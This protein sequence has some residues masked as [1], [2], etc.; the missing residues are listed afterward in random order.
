MVVPTLNEERHVESLL[1][2]L[3]EQSQT[4][5]EV[6]IVDGGSKDKT[7]DIA[8]LYDARV[9]VLP[10]C[11]EFASR[12]VGAKMARGEFLLFTC[13]DI[14]FPNGLLAKVIENFDQTP[15]L[16]ALTGPGYPFGASFFGRI[17]YIVYNVIR[18][19]FAKFPRPFKRFS[20]STNFLVVRK[21]YFDRTGGFKVDEINADGLMGKTLLEMGEVAFSLD[22]YVYISARR[23]ENMGI[24]NFNKHYLYAFENLFFFLSGMRIMKTLKLRSKLEHRKMHVK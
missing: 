16:I 1:A 11:G 3:K 21:D 6:L 7:S 2:S 17:E 4:S 24:L 22:N 8:H 19:L 10:G 13:A 12:N 23:M 5:F 9:V 18:Y 20:T 14:I 15:E